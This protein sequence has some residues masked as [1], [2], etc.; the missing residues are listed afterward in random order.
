MSFN[1]NDLLS[2]NGCDICYEN[3]NNIFTLD[4]C[5]NSKQICIHCISCLTKYICPYCRQDL[6]ERI[7]EIILENNTK[8][9]NYSSSAPDRL[10]NIN[11]WNSFIQ[12]EYLIDPF[13]DYYHNRDSR[14]LRRR[15]RQLR[16]RFLD[17][18]IN[19]LR[20]DNRNFNRNERRRRRK[21][22]RNYTNNLTQ[23]LQRSHSN[24]ISSSMSNS[25][26]LQDIDDDDNFIFNME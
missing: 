6:P 16:K 8:K 21:N 22:L 5:N 15:M 7:S 18:N 20:D 10:N 13:A 19:T 2:G 14:I 3:S 11:D 17:H 1:S 26:S 25:D 24:S 4:C 12:N 23:Y 9:Y